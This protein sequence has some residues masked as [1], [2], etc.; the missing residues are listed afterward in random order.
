MKQ[1][2]YARIGCA[3]CGYRDGEF[4]LHLITVRRFGRALDFTASWECPACRAPWNVSINEETA[5]ELVR[6]GALYIAE[7][8]L[9]SAIDQLMD[10]I[11]HYL[12]TR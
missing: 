2:R 8:E 7:P 12:E 5:N 6:D 3:I 9:R 4:Q 1:V 11:T 10:G